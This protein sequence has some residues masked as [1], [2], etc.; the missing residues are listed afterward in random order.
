[1][2]ACT[3]S[4]RDSRCSLP[5]ADAVRAPRRRA[6]RQKRSRP[7]KSLALRR[8]FVSW[9]G[10]EVDNRAADATPSTWQGQADPSRI[11]ALSDCASM[12][13][14]GAVLAALDHWRYAGAV[15]LPIANAKNRAE[16]ALLPDADDSS[17]TS[18]SRP[19]DTALSSTSAIPA[20]RFAPLKPW[21]LIG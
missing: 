12:N 11:A 20:A 1:S 4:N 21:M 8:R 19:Q 9:L 14:L 2:S 16:A 3:R 13:A 18:P 15:S 6:P 7:A 10:S 5:A 17:A